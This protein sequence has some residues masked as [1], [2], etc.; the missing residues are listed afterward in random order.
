MRPTEHASEPASEKAKNSC[1]L[2][3]SEIEL[4]CVL[5][6]CCSSQASFHG[7]QRLV[8]AN[9]DGGSRT[10]EKSY[11]ARQSRRRRPPAPAVALG[12]REARSATPWTT[13]VG[14]T[15]RLR[16]AA[17]TD[18]PLQRLIWN[19]SGAHS[20]VCGKPL[21][22]VARG[23]GTPVS[24]PHKLM[25]P[26]GQPHAA[27]P[28]PRADVHSHRLFLSKDVEGRARL[29]EAANSEEE[30]GCRHGVT[31]GQDRAAAAQA[32]DQESPC[33]EGKQTRDQTT[34]HAH[35]VARIE[36]HRLLGVIRQGHFAKIY[37]MHWA[38]GAQ[39]SRNLVSASQ[40]YL[41]RR[42]KPERAHGG[43]C[44]GGRVRVGATE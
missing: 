13:P 42:T 24:T 27:H 39:A 22:S 36:P 43:A 1:G 4:N 37:A 30:A 31:G 11:C 44:W 20:R 32:G 28:P 33:A 10:P 21:G 3:S 29:A 34:P 25:E 17:S 12:T 23:P 5:F 16:A 40:V 2:P 7:H 35:T 41:V 19:R 38:E 26:V 6:G 18:T 9:L 8:G 14:R 15:R